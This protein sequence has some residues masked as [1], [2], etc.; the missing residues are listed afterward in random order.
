MCSCNK[1][2]RPAAVP[3]AAPVGAG[4]PAPRT[5]IL[6]PA[7]AAPEPAAAD[8]PTV[9]TSVWGSLLWR[10]LHTASV[11]TKTRQHAQLWRSLLSA[12]KTGIPCPDCSAHYNAWIARH[13]LRFSVIRNGIR[14]PIVRWVL[15]L[16]NEVNRRTGS[17]FGSWTVKQVM[18]TYQDRTAASAAL[19]ALQG[20]IGPK[21]YEAATA[22]LNSL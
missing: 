21:A 15:D 22:L 17:P 14:G 11:A 4:R 9:D 1:A 5:A 7:A 16:H 6:A 10:V 19:L 3:S 20:V 2:R 13:G 12:L 18:D 8:I